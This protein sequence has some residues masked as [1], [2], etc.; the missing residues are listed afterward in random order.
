MKLVNLFESET[1]QGAYVAVKFSQESVGN[2]E[3]FRN[4]T[5]V[6][7]PLESSE[8]H[9]TLIYSAKPPNAPIKVK[10]ALDEAAAVTGL[11]IFVAKDEKNALVLTLSSDFLQKRHKELMEE[12]DLSYDFEEYI[13][14]ITISYDCGDYDI[15]HIEIPDYLKDLEIV[16]EYKESLKKDKYSKV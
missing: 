9:C 10:G 8:F 2:V 3:K 11:K 12:Y 7:N 6:K 13:P 5:G 14:H 4:E 1:E 16:L 15:D